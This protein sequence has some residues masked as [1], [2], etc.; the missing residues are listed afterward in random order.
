MSARWKY[1]GYDLCPR[2]DGDVE[3]L[4]VSPVSVRL[5]E[6]ARCK[7]CSLKGVLIADDDDRDS[8]LINW[9]K[10][11]D[12]LAKH[13]IAIGKTKQGKSYP[14]QERIDAWRANRN[15]NPEAGTPPDNS[16]VIRP[17]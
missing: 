5:G 6:A 16:P 11:P 13:T 3:T 17:R 12:V 4:S 7:E 1:F 2:C 15:E 9:E 8:V 14:S 10:S